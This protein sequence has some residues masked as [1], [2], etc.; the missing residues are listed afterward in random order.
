MEPYTCLRDWLGFLREGRGNGGMSFE[1]AWPESVE[2]A[3]RMAPE[4]EQEFWRATF[5]EQRDAW[6]RGYERAEQT[7]AEYALTVLFETRGG[8]VIGDGAPC[9]VCD[10]PIPAKRIG[11]HAKY[12]SDKCR[13]EAEYRRLAA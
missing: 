9:A 5:A 12:C 6:Q 2:R 11:R 4:S 8:G 10:E 3:V 7:P 13:R 1:Q